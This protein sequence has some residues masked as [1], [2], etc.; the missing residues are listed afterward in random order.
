MRLHDLVDSIEAY[1]T[2]MHVELKSLEAWWVLSFFNNMI[3]ID[4]E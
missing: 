2:S 4:T 1:S 3:V